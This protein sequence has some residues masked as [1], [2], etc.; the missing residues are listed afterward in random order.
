[1]AIIT[2][3]TDWGCANHYVGAVKGT[4]LKLIPGVQ[5]VDISHEIP[6]FDIMQASFVLKNAFP[7][8][9]EGTIHLLG[10]NTEAGLQ[11]PHIAVKQQ[12]Q[13]F[14]GADNGIFS[15]LFDHDPEEAVEVELLQDSDYFTFSTRDVFAKA[16]A[17][18]ASAG[19]IRELGKPHKELNQRIPFRPVIYPEKIIGK[20]IFIDR[21]DN[22]LVNIDRELFRQV[23]RNRPFTIHFRSP[24][25]SITQ[26]HQSYADVVP[27]EK[28]ALFGS[29]GYLE[30][31][32]NQGKASSLLGLYMND[33]VSIEFN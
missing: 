10:V 22:V 23:G 28:L 18:I 20:V 19:G 6:P 9:P 3:T 32:I 11:T 2:L 15:L 16:A 26:I 14:V 4:L 27:G 17:M 12:A 8:F 30:I 29:T 24:G 31:A 1:M 33:T 13:F 25:Y 5:I 21:Y 7:H